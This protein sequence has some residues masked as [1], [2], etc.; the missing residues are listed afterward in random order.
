[1]QLDPERRP[2]PLRG[3]LNAA[4]CVLLAAGVPSAALAADAPPNPKWQFDGSGLLYSER[5]RTRVIEPIARITRLFPDGQTLSAQ[6]AL[7]AV[8]G[9]SPTGALPSGRIQTRTTPSGNVQTIPAG[10]IP[11]HGYHDLR[12]ALDL[13]WLRPFGDRL[14]YAT[15][16]H[17]SREKDYASLGL[18]A[19]LSASFMQKLTTVSVGGGFNRDSVI[20]VGG[21]PTPLSDAPGTDRPASRAKRVATGVLGISRILTR[22][23]MV[24]VDASRTVERGYLTEPYKVVSLVDPATGFTTGELTEGRPSNRDRKDVLASSAYH[25]TKD[26]IYASYRYYWDDWQVRSNTIDLKV[27]HELA[28]Q[29]WVQPH[30]RF[31]D[32]TAARFFTTGFIQG[33]PIPQYA[34][35]D[36]RLGSLHTVTLGVTYGFH[37]ADYPGE[38]TVRAEYLRQ[39]GNGHPDDEEGVQQQF[40][41]SPA[42]NVG[43]LM[44]T[45]TVR[46]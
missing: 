7:D 6:L 10:A 16:A 30:L 36:S 27:R 31:Y 3:K 19:K 34:T 8:T 26:I 44:L 13:Q 24:G 40:D 22:R 23:W 45:Y 20:P 4:A 41:L 21:V 39:W 11:T 15:G 38:F 43:T 35:S 2:S 33:S 14:T 28:N 37:S 29:R 17:L 1:V 18:N 9:A 46:F 5:Q 42:L 12:A 32:Q 25:L